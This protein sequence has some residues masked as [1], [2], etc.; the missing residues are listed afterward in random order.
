[1]VEAT[2]LG[3]G[4]ELAGFAAEEKSKNEIKRHRNEHFTDVSK[5]DAF[6]EFQI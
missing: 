3:L 4:V 5:Y 2:A 1:M 6:V